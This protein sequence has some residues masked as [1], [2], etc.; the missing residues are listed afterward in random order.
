M[1]DPRVALGLKTKAFVEAFVLRHLRLPAF[2]ALLEIIEL[3]DEINRE[4]AKKAL[5]QA[6][7]HVRK[8][9]APRT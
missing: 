9:S 4:E 6:I 5:E 7:E 3:N 8:H 2:K 1:T